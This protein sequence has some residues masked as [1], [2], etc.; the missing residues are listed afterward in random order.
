MNTRTT[1]DLAAVRR[2]PNRY[3][4][5]RVISFHDIGKYSFIEYESNPNHAGDKS[6]T[7]YSVYVDCENTSFSCSSLEA[8]MLTAIGYANL[9]INAG[10]HMA[11]AACKILDVP[12]CS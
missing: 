2:Q 9:G 7:L 11:I 8:A 1:T 5:G 6:K 3:T 12:V 10:S 4:W